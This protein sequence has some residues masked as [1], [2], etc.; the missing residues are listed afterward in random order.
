[1]TILLYSWELSIHP[2]VDL[3][4]LNFR[5]LFVKMLKMVF[6]RVVHFKVLFSE[7]YQYGENQVAN[8][9]CKISYLYDIGGFNAW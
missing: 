6:R 8:A 1:M 4:F 5:F 3:K 7:K 2:L 9:N